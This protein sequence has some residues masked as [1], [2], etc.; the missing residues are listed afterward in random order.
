MLSGKG[1]PGKSWREKSDS[2]IFASEKVV[3]GIEKTLK[4]LI[5]LET[6]KE[7]TFS[8]VTALTRFSEEG[9][10]YAR[11]IIME[12]GIEKP[13]PGDK[14][15]SVFVVTPSFNA[16]ETIDRT[17]QSVVSQ[18]GNFNLHYHIQDG[19]SEDDTLDKVKAWKRIVDSESFHRLCNKISFS[20]VS[21]QDSGIYDAIVRGF[22]LISPGRDAYMAWINADDY[23]HIGAIANVIKL[24][25][26]HK[27]VQWAGGTTDVHDSSG[28][29]LGC[30][31][32]VFPQK[33]IREGLCD[34]DHWQMIQ[35]EGIFW[36]KSLWDKVGGLNRELKFAGD[37]DLWRR[38]AQ[39]SQLCMF[40]WPQGSFQQR[41]GQASSQWDLYRREMDSIVTKGDRT[42]A[43]R[44]IAQ[45]PFS[46]NHI[47][48]YAEAVPGTFTLKQIFLRPESMPNPARQLIK[49]TAPEAFNIPKRTRPVDRVGEQENV[50]NN[51]NKYGKAAGGFMKSGF[52]RR[53]KSIWFLPYWIVIQHSQLF[54]TSYYLERNPDVASSR[55]N[56]LMHYILHGAGEG[57][58]PNPLFNSRWY[59]LRNPDVRKDSV[60]PL[61]HYI[62]FGWKEGRD[63]GPDFSIAG[64][65][66][67]NPDVRRARIDPLKHF[68]L[69]GA[70]EG[71]P[72]GVFLGS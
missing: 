28:A 56:P 3:F 60:N 17:I 4:K 67:K 71:R 18:Q 41:D 15:P 38:F 47:S 36:R 66:D 30:Y 20:W 23:L 46:L 62:R 2:T 68:L 51:T 55:I 12:S 63:P 44:E 26:Q 35:Q 64:Y 37:W 53:N 65:L 19:G 22:E 61:F 59:V 9:A 14:I 49:E 43:L 16:A 21:E 34:R 7:E 8:I 29:K 32:A 72:S 13:A 6:V 5:S 58:N 31:P 24:F 57:R 45:D 27:N 50:G 1:F 54:F 33:V 25:S 48:V 42:K 70:G 11:D 52:K 10:K 69:H 40:P 39:H